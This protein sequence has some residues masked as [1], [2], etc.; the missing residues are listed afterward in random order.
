MQQDILASPTADSAETPTRIERIGNYRITGEIGAGGMAIVYKGVQESLGRIVAIK[1]LKTALATEE[2]LRARFE[3][4]AL[5]VA[6]FQ[7]ENII[8]LYDFFH[9]EDALYMVMEYVEGIDLY[10]LL[11]KEPK[12]PPDVAAIIALQVARALDHAHFRGVIHRDVK[13]ANIM[14]SK[15]GE[16]KLTDF[17][18]ARTQS[19][20]LTEAGIGLG[21]PSYMSPEQIVGDPL[22][23]RSDIWSLGVVLYQLVAG[24]KPFLDDE[25][26]TAMQRIRNEQVV[27]PRQI[28]PECPKDLEWVILKC[29]QKSAEDRYGSTQE[30]VNVLEQYVASHVATNYR[31]RMVMFLKTMAVVSEDETSA[32]L[33]PALIGECSDLGPVGLRFSHGSNDRSWLLP[34]LVGVGLIVGGGLGWL[35]GDS[36]ES[37]GGSAA[38]SAIPCPSAT[39]Q[40]GQGLLRVVAYPWAHVEIDGQKVA[41]TPF[42]RPIPLRAGKHEIVLSN[43]YFAPFKRTINIVEG[44]VVNIEQVLKPTGSQK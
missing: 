33:H 7:H 4:E 26:R 44:R 20:D 23:H 8:T 1:A 13:P 40:K 38:N 22:D 17:G 10:D 37:S 32:M 30:L 29:M 39:Q 16:V 15:L 9:E 35:I 19:S 34:L 2:S 24:R 27:P 28:N 14:V 31:V 21:T 41:T 25:E 42:Y 12:L 3:R 18:I 6:S 5:S 11:E 36:G 43:P